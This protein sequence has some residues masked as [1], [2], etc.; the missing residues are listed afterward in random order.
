MTIDDETDMKALEESVRSIEKDGL[1]WGQSK[2]V[3]VGFGI[4]KLQ[5]NLVI[6][7]EKISLDDLQEEIQAFED[8]VQS[9]DIVSL[10][11]RLTSPTNMYSRRRCKNSKNVGRKQPLMDAFSRQDFDICTLLDPRTCR[12][13]TSGIFRT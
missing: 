13:R 12:T 2:L 5:I 11:C 4:K 7:D 1:V 6:E 8:Y 3:P 10:R 9:T